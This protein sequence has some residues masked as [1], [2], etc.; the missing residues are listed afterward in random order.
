M[1]YSPV[2]KILLYILLGILIG[3]QYP[4]WLGDGGLLALWKLKHEIT[5]QKKENARLKAAQ[6]GIF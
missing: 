3:L 6:L 1:S 4:L 2:V 5:V